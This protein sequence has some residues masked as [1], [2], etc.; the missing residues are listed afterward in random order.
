LARPGE[1]F[2]QDGILYMK[3]EPVEDAV[4]LSHGH[5]HTFGA[6]VHVLPVEGEFVWRERG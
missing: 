1:V 2:L 3:T 5:R 4:S 6:T